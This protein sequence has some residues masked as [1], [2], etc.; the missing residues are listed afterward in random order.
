[1]RSVESEVDRELELLD[2][3]DG[4]PQRIETEDDYSDITKYR[5]VWYRRRKQT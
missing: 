1:V 5:G 2:I 4:K 3:S